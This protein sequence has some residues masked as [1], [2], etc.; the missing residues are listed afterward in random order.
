M[1]A[2]EF[3]PLMEKHGKGIFDDAAFMYRPRALYSEEARD[4]SRALAS[5]LGQPLRIN[6]AIFKDD[7]EF[8]GWSFGFQENAE[9]FYMC[10][11]AILPEHRRKGLYRALLTQMVDRAL[12]QGFQRIYSR[13]IATNNAVI[14]PKLQAGFVITALELSD[15]FGTLVHLTYLAHSA[16]RKV[17]NFRAGIERPDAE[18]RSLFGL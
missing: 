12:K 4:R 5:H 13:H 17:L 16:R 1:D 2:A 3:G 15:V 6:L 11:S 8:V 18:T 10:N 14:I 9:T 7:G